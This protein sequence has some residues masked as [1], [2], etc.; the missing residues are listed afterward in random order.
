VS[1]AITTLW[2]DL[3]TVEEHREPSVP[4]VFDD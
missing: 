4:D 3:A 1:D 2:F